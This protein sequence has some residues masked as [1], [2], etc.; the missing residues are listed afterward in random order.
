MCEACVEMIREND[1]I[2]YNNKKITLKNL[3]KLLHSK[4]INETQ[5]IFKNYRYKLKLRDTKGYLLEKYEV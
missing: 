4:K 1:V 2:L 3:R 5:F